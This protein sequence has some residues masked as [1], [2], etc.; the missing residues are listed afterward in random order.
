MSM[1][2]CCAAFHSFLSEILRTV[3]GDSLL[4][5]FGPLVG[6]ESDSD[7]LRTSERYF[8]IGFVLACLSMASTNE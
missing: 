3:E 7:M 8:G 4:K 5:N 2:I 6:F 1:V